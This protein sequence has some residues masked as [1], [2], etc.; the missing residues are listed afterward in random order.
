[1]KSYTV[2]GNVHTTISL[3]MNNIQFRG[4]FQTNATF[5]PTFRN[6]SLAF[7]NYMKWYISTDEKRNHFVIKAGYLRRSLIEPFK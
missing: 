5:V 6:Y 2:K 4:M 7:A 3:I 1:M